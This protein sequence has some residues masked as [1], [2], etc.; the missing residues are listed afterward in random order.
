MLKRGKSSLIE[1]KIAL[2]RQ[3]VE[4]KW[5]IAPRQVSCF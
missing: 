1:I 3:R 4:I 5:I 2:E